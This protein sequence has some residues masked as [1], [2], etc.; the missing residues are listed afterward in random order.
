MHPQ[1]SQKIDEAVIKNPDVLEDS[2]TDEAVIPLKIEEVRIP[3][4]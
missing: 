4:V 2:A 3:G 1:E